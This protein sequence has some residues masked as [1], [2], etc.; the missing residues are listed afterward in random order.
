MDY[1]KL[2]DFEINKAVAELSD[3]P[4]DFHITDHTVTRHCKNGY[5]LPEILAFDPCNDPA[6]AWPIIVENNISL[7]KPSVNGEWY[8]TIPSNFNGWCRDKNPLRAAMTMYL[9]MKAAKLLFVKVMPE[10]NLNL[11]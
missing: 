3:N 6:D 9:M 11:F 5:T 4:D 10:N 7:E 1:S 8:I 2:S